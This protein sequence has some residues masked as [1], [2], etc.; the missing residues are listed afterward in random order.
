MARIKQNQ[1]F[2]LIELMITVVIL[3]IFAAI[4]VPSFTAFV[5]NNRLQSASNELASLLLFA[6]SNAVQNNTAHIV[7]LSAGT[8][9]V[10]RASLCTSTND[11]RSIVSPA[12]INIAASA[13][14]MPMT[15][16]PNGTTSNSPR[17]IACNGT[18]AASGYLFTVKN[19]GQ[20]RVWSKGKNEA[21][22][23][24]TSCTP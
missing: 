1:G 5:N 23:T 17:F 9:T 7:C 12:S 4:A 3:G 16:N 21:G 10:K 14:A 18:D 6:R 15:F 2:T 19:T 13:S 8:W 24:L 22:A 20:V 11:L